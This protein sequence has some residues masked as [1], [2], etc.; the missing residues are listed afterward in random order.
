MKSN[1]NLF[2]RIRPIKNITLKTN[3]NNK[4]LGE[5]IKEEEIL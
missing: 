4:S 2:D 5:M 3:S 1:R